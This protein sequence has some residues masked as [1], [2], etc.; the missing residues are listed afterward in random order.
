MGNATSKQETQGESHK[1]SELLREVHGKC[2]RKA[3]NKREE[4]KTKGLESVGG[5]SLT[6]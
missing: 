1:D 5:C 2:R 3:P 4:G 6:K